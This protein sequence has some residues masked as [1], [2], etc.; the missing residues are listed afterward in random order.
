MKTL[1]INATLA[2]D[3]RW[4]GRHFY[5][6]DFEQIQQRTSAKH[7]RKRMAIVESVLVRMKAMMGMGRGKNLEAFS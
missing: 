6:E 5:E 1:L 2:S 3:S 7:V 4:I